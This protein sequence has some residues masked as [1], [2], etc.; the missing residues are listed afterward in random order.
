MFFLNKI[1]LDGSNT[2]SWFYLYFR[3]FYERL[4]QNKG[5]NHYEACI[6]KGISNFC[7]SLSCQ[8]FFFK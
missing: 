8:Q 2:L 4:S 1:K 7:L 3:N 6:M 5:A